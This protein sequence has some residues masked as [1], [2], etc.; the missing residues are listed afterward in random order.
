MAYGCVRLL[1]FYLDIYLPF[2]SDIHIDARVVAALVAFSVI[3]AVLFGLVPAVQ[4]S[5]APAQEAL[6]E[7]TPATGTGRQQR[8]FAMPLWWAK[9]PFR[10]CC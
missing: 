2:S 7:G 6:R 9:S 8:I 10:C 1:K 5:R 3:S 4:A